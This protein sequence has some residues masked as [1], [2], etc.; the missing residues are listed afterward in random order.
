[1]KSFQISSPRLNF[2]ENKKTACKRRLKLN[3][4]V[5]DYFNSKDELATNL[6]PSNTLIW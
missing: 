1:M 5:G 4:V 6:G 3:I 2:S